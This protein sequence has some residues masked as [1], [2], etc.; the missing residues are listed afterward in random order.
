MSRLKSNIR[1]VEQKEHLV[2]KG[3]KP[4]TGPPLGLIPVW[5]VDSREE[6]V[7]AEVTCETQSQGTRNTGYLPRLGLRH[8]LVSSGTPSRPLRPQDTFCYGLRMD[9]RKKVTTKPT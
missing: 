9:T 7:C 4:I 6:R 1:V 3:E 8:T 2:K 5:P